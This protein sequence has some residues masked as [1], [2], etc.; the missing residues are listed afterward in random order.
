MSGTSGLL[1]WGCVPLLLG[2]I[3]AAPPEPKGMER[4][5]GGTYEALYKSDKLQTKVSVEPFYLDRYPV[6]ER[7][8]A[9]FIRKHPRWRS[10]NISPLFAD[11]KYLTTV[12]LSD[13]SSRP[14]TSVSWFAAKAYCRSKGK[15]LP[16]TNE[17]E[18][19]ALASETAVD[20]R[21]DPKFMAKV[22]E[23]Y[24]S[25]STD[26]LPEVGQ[27][28]RNVWGVFDMHGL[29]WEWVSDFNSALTIGESRNAGTVDPDL[30]CGAAA[31]GTTESQKINYPAFLRY[32]FRSSLEGT[33]A[34]HN[35][36]FRCAMDAP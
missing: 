22:S 3:A 26:S 33:Y 15:R 14:V 11:D 4:I 5:A 28:F 7:D 2:V 18:F 9:R 17:W 30:F 6:T 32:A 23:W 12:N 35:L 10:E 36:G 19:V 13:P 29:V 16:T 20:G 34:V 27:G 8:F 31:V 24:G 25:P 21:G 1:R